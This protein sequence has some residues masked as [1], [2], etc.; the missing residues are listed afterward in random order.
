M[1]TLRKHQ[2]LPASGGADREA[3][4]QKGQFW[5]PD[6]VADALA[7]YVLGGGATCVL[8]PAVGAGAFFKAIRRVAADAGREVAL[9]GHEID[10]FAL[11]QAEAEGVSA[12]DLRNVVLRDFVLQPQEG[13]FPAIIANPPYLR[14]HRIPAD[15]KARLKTFGA[16]VLGKPLDGRAGLHI[17]FLLRALTLLSPNGRLA[18]LLPADTCEGKFAA[19]LWGFITRH[20]RVDAVVSF[21]QAATPFPHVDTNV[22]AFLITNAPPLPVFASVYCREPWNAD[23]RRYIETGEAGPTLTATPRDL[24]E[25]LSTGFSRA[26][27]LASEAGGPVLGDFA[28]V[29]RGIATGDNEFFFLTQAQARD[30]ELP[31]AFLLP[32]VGRTRDVQTEI[33]TGARLKEL[34]AEG[35]PTLLLSPDNRSAESFPPALQRYL[36]EGERRGLPGRALISQRTPWHRMERRAPP[37]FLFAYLGR[38]N[39]RFIRNDAQALPLTGFLC[40]YPKQSDA[41][42]A[43]GLWS[44][45]RHPDTV[46]ALSIVGKS[47]GSGAIKVEPRGMERLPLPRDVVAA[48]GL[49][50]PR[51]V[52]ETGA[53]GGYSVTK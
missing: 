45:L 17:Y 48:S 46:A 47:Y 39:A 35:R 37:P 43:A 10:P 11:S 49:W 40:V 3:L 23:L 1:P 20:F 26:P 7:A 50:E 15:I 9:Y 33:L 25:A 5:T 31:A 14:H 28:R 52:L 19:D 38:R 13:P 2:N 53:E 32:A 12:A 22:L 24:C 6:W 34:D 30:L 51:L 4:R 42:F 29:M 8:D 41:A 16:T 21:A 44:V 36:A 18:F 27:R